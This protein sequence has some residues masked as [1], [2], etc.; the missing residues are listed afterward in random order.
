MS[1]VSWEF[2]LLVAKYS[3]QS[4]TMLGNS[5]LALA[6]RVCLLFAFDAFG[7]RSCGSVIIKC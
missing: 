5:G 2:A 3:R 4:H 7:V 1:F 6:I